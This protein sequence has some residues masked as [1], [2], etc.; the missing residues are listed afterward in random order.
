M[1]FK[2]GSSAEQNTSKAISNCLKELGS[3][4]PDII[5]FTATVLHDFKIIKD[6]IHKKFPSTPFHGGSS[7]QGTMSNTGVHRNEGYGLSIMAISDPEGD[8]GTSLIEIND[9]AIGAGE[10]AINS[11][12]ENS[13]RFG[14]LPN[15]I[16]L[17]PAPGQ[18]EEIIEGIQSVI[19]TNVP[20][21]GGSSGDNTIEGNW[22]QCTQEGIKQ[23]AIGL[24]V[25]YTDHILTTSFHSGYEVT[26]NKGIVTK[27][28]HREILEID[29][30]KATDV[31]NKWSGGAIDEALA[32]HGSIVNI[33][34]HSGLFPIG[35]KVGD[36]HDV[37]YYKLSH[38]ETVT[39][40][41]SVTLFTDIHEG[42]E[43]ICM[44]GTVDGIVQRAKNV[45]KASMDV[46]QLK[47]DDIAGGLMTFCAGCMLTI[48][49]DI[50]NAHKSI[51]EVLG[52]DT[53]YLSAFTFGEQGTFPGGENCHGNLMIAVLLFTH[54]KIET[55]L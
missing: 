49:E 16:W 36:I 23:N 10:E 30:K 52:D 41:G 17:M 40:K 53:P 54:K 6:E 48:G 13:C 3:I 11:A 21:V 45:V 50:N 7:C 38:P 5:I 2:T 14:E 39:P 55:N 46:E 9:S 51:H 20:I 8:Y 27:S 24:T 37:P 42:D 47:P 15:A 1:I 26:E 12:I 29:N 44:S 19:G 25:I 43:V 4:S 31:Y 22:I 35:R 28:T 33:L 32:D 34:G 18:E